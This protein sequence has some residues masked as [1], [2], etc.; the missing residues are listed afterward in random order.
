METTEAGMA[1]SRTVSVVIPTHN[2][3]V[4]LPALFERLCN[5]TAAIEGSTFEFVF[6]D[7][8][9]T[10]DTP[11]LLAAL[12]ARDSRVRAVRFSKNFGSHAACL[13]GMTMARGHVVTL[14]SADLQDPPELM[15]AMLAKL[16]AG[17]DVVFAYRNERDEPRLKVVLS[18]IYHRLM[19]KY[20]MPNWPAQGADVVMMRRA[21]SDILVKWKQKNTSLFAQMVWTG[22]RQEFIPYT[23]KKRRAGKS[24]WTLAKKVK[25]A[26]DSFASFSFS[27]IRFMSYVGI[28]VSMTGFAYAGVVVYGRLVH[29]IRVEGFAT[30]LVVMLVLGGFQLLMLGVLGEYLWRVAD[31]VRGAPAFII[32]ETLGIDQEQQ[33]AAWVAHVQVGE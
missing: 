29:N 14:L 7:D 28:V 11:V 27:P 5:V 24:K 9:S 18:N 19:R 3:A 6:V 26:V 21:V 17:A 16:D 10:D 22:F 13:A 25:L 8:R 12:H 15:A 33:P 31:E 32:E 4:N 2:E 20:A 30:L 1:D 23:R